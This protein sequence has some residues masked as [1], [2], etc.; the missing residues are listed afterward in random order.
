MCKADGPNN[1]TDRRKEPVLWKAIRLGVSI[2]SHQTFLIQMFI[3]NLIQNWE[4][5]SRGIITEIAHLSGQ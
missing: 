4:S 2:I 1:H 3:P 5:P